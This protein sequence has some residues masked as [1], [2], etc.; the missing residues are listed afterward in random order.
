M[1]DKLLKLAHQRYQ[2]TDKA[3]RK[4]KE[5]AT[6]LLNFVA[7]NQWNENIKQRFQNAGFSAATSPRIQVML[8]QITNEL[9]KNPPQ[10]QVDPF[11]DTDKEKAEILNDLIRNIQLECDAEEAYVKAAEF[12]AMVGIGYFR[13]LTELVSYDSFDQ[14]ILIQPIT[15]VNSVMLD[16]NHKDSTGSDSEYAFITTTYTVAEYKSKF[17]NT[18]MYQL[19]SEGFYS[20]GDE[21]ISLSQLS[22]NTLDPERGTDDNGQNTVVVCEYFYKEYKKETLN[23]V[24]DEQTGAVFSTFKLKELQEADPTAVYTILKSRDEQ[25]PVIKWAKLNEVEVLE[26]TEWYGRFIPIIAVKADEY[27]IENDRKLVGAVEPAQDTQ[28]QLNYA[29]TYTNRALQM[30]PV[31]PWLVTPTM[32][33][34]FTDIWKNA[35]VS[36]ASVLP[37]NPD[38]AMPGATPQQVKYEPPIQA[39]SAM[40][41]SA[42]QGLNAIFG[43]FDAANQSLAPESGKA[44]LAR[45]DQSYNSNYHFYDNLKRSVKQAGIIIVDIIPE[46]YDAT[47]Q[48]QL[49]S[50]DGKK[51]SI[52]INKPLE[53]NVIEHDMTSG[54]F[55]VSIETGPGFGT[56]RQESAESIMDL[57][58]VYPQAAPA[59]AD[60]AV[61]QMDWPG[62]DKIA[63]SL[64]AM[65]PPQVLQA[66]KIDPKNAAAMVPGLQSQVTQ[67]TQ[68]LQA[69]QLEH[70][71]GA[72]LLK[73]KAAEHQL[74]LAKVQLQEKSI[75]ST[76]KI[77]LA[78]LGIKKKELQ[79]DED[80]AF[81][82]AQ[83]KKEDLKI[84]KG[85]FK[86]KEKEFGLELA[87]TM[88]TMVE[89]HHDKQVAHIDRMT[90]P[91]IELDNVN[92][93]NSDQLKQ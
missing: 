60:I 58:G 24:R 85:E 76:E 22:W 44:R 43:V 6:T 28:R 3:W 4:Q 71:Q 25:V 57:I 7:G 21:E 93:S 82:D 26:E 90:M 70:Q 80:K 17:P 45:Q 92:E 81:L 2:D 1:D 32:M 89:E 27:W 69:M 9:R 18:K 38:P 62:A 42:E 54:R 49:T 13:I 74:E 61:R 79:L 63:D 72:L 14:K 48:V 31:A 59:I 50:Q 36:N 16:P 41:Q 15:D 40:Y 75:E 66:R 47:R 39:A 46:I 53:N 34:N 37:F 88:N 91:E 83:F 87:E 78:E 30:S 56:K 35:N 20:D 86:L 84:A 51:R 77:K 5:N 68:Q 29:M 23:L 33:K 12:A 10:I 65:V 67:L 73:D 64:Q 55:G 19:L 8:R 11:N 52:V